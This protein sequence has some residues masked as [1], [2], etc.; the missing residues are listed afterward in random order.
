ME[1]KNIILSEVTQI[2]NEHTWYVVTDKW[3]LTQ[4]LGIPNTDP[5]KL[6][7]EEQSVDVSVLKWRNKILM[8]GNMGTKGGAGTERRPSRD[9]PSW[10]YIPYID[11]KPRHYCECHE[12]LAD[13]SLTWLSHVRP[14]QSLTN[15]EA[16]ACSKPLYGVQG[17]QCRC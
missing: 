8:G 14:S 2:T 11:T 1:L 15:T 7:K 17:S 13:R 6:K 12:V 4:K 10:G 3:I 16:D 5:M 9:F